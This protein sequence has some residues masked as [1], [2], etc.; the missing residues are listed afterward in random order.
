MRNGFHHG[1]NQPLSDSKHCN[2]KLYSNND[3]DS[4]NIHQH[5][6]AD[7]PLLAGKSLS[8]ILHLVITPIFK[9]LRF[10]L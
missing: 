1:T 4:G 9:H 8:I 10:T 7:T 5:I 6:T 2:G 3:I